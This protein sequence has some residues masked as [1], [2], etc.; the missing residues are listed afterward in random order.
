MGKWFNGFRLKPYYGPMPRNPFE[1]IKADTEPDT[2]KHDK[3]VTSLAIG[4]HKAGNRDHE[5]GND[6]HDATT[7]SQVSGTYETGERAHNPD[8]GT[9]G[10]DLY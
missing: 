9:V 3:T 2:G 8:R 6:K 10:P 7:T 1:Q 4:K 5:P